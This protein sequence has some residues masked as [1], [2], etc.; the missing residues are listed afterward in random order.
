MPAAWQP[1]CTRASQGADLRP[2]GRPWWVGLGTGV[3][4]GVVGCCWVAIGLGLELV[5]IEIGVRVGNEIHVI[6]GVRAMTKEQNMET[7]LSAACLTLPC[8]PDWIQFVPT[9]WSMA[10]TKFISL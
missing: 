9:C 1:H 8:F 3:G 10:L 6:V 7:L 2:G 5:E 4:D